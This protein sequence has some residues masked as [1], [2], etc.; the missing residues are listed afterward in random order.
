MGEKREKTQRRSGEHFPIP[1]WKTQGDRFH[2]FIVFFGKMISL[3]C[4]ASDVSIFARHH[5]IFFYRI[6]VLFELK[7]FCFD[8]ESLLNE[9]VK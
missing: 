2:L 5:Q 3:L 1:T 6:E 8:I 7:G 4:L 9:N